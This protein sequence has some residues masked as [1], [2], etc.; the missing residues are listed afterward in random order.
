MYT[1]SSEYIDKGQ[2]NLPMLF[3]HLSNTLC[4]LFFESASV[5]D[6]RYVFA[7]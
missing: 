6:V 7:I 4:I 2:Q 5:C 3:V 1:L